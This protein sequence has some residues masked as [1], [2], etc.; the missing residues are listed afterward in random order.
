MNYN[1]LLGKY[2]LTQLYYQFQLAKEIL[3]GLS[4]S[5]EGLSLAVM[6]SS[7]FWRV[8]WLLDRV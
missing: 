3:A 4:I 5:T 1:Q 8:S 2:I 7:M 6:Y